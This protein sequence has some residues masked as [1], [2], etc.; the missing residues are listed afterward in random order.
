LAAAGPRRAHA[1][2][3]GTAAAADRA[4]DRAEAHRGA[5]LAAPPPCRT[6]RQQLAAAAAS[7]RHQ[8]R[9]A[10]ERALRARA[11]RAA[12][13]CTIARSPGALCCVSDVSFCRARS[14]RRADIRVDE[15]LPLLREALA[16]ARPGFVSGSPPASHIK[17]KQT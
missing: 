7:R 11:P 2:A 10:H 4:A 8:A 6:A 15:L 13:R 5:P 17:T 16:G 14:T 12:A 1:G 9:R 3:G